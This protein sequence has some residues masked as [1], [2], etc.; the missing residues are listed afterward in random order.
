MK[1][2]LS[3][4]LLALLLAF[5]LISLTSNN[6]SSAPQPQQ[7]LGVAFPYNAIVSGTFNGTTIVQAPPDKS[8][9]ITQVG[10]RYASINHDIVFHDAIAGTATK[11][12]EG[13]DTYNFKLTVS[14]ALVL[15]PN[16]SLTF[17]EPLSGYWSGYMTR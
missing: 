5:G 12:T 3:T 7:G 10:T 8:I 16:D 15:K 1:T 17:T 4:I 6:L 2:S 13:R 14:P 11:I 9:Y